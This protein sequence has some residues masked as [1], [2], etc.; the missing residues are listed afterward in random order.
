LDAQHGERAGESVQVPWS[1]G[2]ERPSLQA[3]PGATDC[4]HHIY[5][6]RFQPDPKAVLKPAPATVADYRLFQ[7]RIGTS[8]NVVV[9]P[10]TYGV[11]NRCLLD[12]LRQ[13]G[14]KNTRG[15]AVVNTS[16]SDAE[17][18]ELNAAGVRGI[19][20]NL[21]QAG[22][23]SLDM[24]AALAKRI[25]PLG[26]HVQM[27]VS[28]EQILGARSAIKALPCPIVFDHFGHTTIRGRE[29]PAFAVIV[30]L[31]QTGKGWLK[32]SGAYIDSKVGSPSYA[33]S[34]PTARAY[35]K[36]APERL[37]WGSDWPHPTTN[38]KPDDAVLFDLLLQWAPDA[39]ER[40]R[41]LVENPAKLYG[42]A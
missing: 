42:F 7:K 9:Q 30:D 22:A 25:T 6:A 4:H 24:L 40:Y 20:F 26:W 11:D 31:L 38:D 34:V 10:S 12:S 41:I 23:T 5:D 36:E 13:F 1:A 28:S 35:I 14:T 21:Q 3:P 17:L 37:V 16:V 33:E 19:R 2:T 8:R 18:K 32:L 29:D 27:N 15:I 39:R